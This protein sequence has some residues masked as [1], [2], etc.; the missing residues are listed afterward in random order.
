MSLR[1]YL[2]CYNVDQTPTAWTFPTFISWLAQQLKNHRSDP[3]FCCRCTSPLLV[4]CLDVVGGS[5]GLGVLVYY[6]LVTAPSVVFVSPDFGIGKIRDL[7]K[8][9]WAVL[10]M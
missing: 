8:Q 2:Q 10:G 1:D 9:N 4:V 3:I 5:I 7:K 6:Q